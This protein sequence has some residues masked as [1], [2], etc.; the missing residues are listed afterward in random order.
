MSAH[1]FSGTIGTSLSTYVQPARVP[2]R[3]TVPTVLSAFAADTEPA[4]RSYVETFV[5]LRAHVP[6]DTGGHFAAWERPRAYAA[7]L[8]RALRLAGHR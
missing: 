8:R 4:P 2:R 5:D 6:H 1:W 7:D 3:T